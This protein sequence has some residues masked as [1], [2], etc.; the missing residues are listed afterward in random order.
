MSRR[1][2]FGGAFALWIAALSGLVAPVAAQPDKP[3]RVEVSS[4]A[5]DHHDVSP[6]LRDIP[7]AARPPQ[8]NEVRP[9]R[10]VPPFGTANAG[11]SVSTPNS[12]PT[13]AAAPALLSR[14]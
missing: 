6:P 1:L 13:S 11:P 2:L 10:K 12:A 3:T 7:P 8:R 4:T 5:A 14:N 9:W